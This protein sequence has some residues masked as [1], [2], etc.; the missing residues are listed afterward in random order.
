MIMTIEE[1]R[2]I[3]VLMSLKEK[4][5]THL[6]MADV[7]WMYEVGIPVLKIAIE[8]IPLACFENGFYNWFNN[9]NHEL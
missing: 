7:R 6:T 5:R 9:K 1:K 4:E 3:E 8:N 2:F